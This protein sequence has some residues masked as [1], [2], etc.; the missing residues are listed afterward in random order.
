MRIIE[1]STEVFA[2]IWALRQ[3]GEESEDVILRRILFAESE[4]TAPK[5][6]ENSSDLTGAGLGYVEERYGVA[7]PEDF[8][9][10]RVY[11]GK[12]YSARAKSGR[13]LLE[14]TGE[15]FPNLN[16]LSRAVTS[17]PENAWKNWFYIDRDGQRKAVDSLRDDS[18]VIS[19]KR[20][21][22]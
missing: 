8:R 7:V 6:K 12:D 16:Q 13:W 3:H 2:K 20:W 10:Y 15:I 19:R 4:G 1:V 9:I 14:Q 18:K 5:R 11:L 17:G 21:P 22:G